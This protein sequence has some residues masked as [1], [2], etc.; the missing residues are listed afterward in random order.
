M[1]FTGLMMSAALTAGASAAIT[2]AKKIPLITVIAS[3][4]IPTP[5]SFPVK[6]VAP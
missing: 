5:A 2:L 3:R 1:V 6:R 4:V